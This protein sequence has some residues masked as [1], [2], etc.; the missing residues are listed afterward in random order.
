MQ[1]VAPAGPV[2]AGARGRGA[3]R[4]G[5]GHGV[6]LPLLHQQSIARY[7]VG[8]QLGQQ[9]LRHPHQEQLRYALDEEVAHPRRHLVGA[10][11]AIVDVQDYDGDDYGERHHHH[12]E[13]D[14]LAQQRQGEGGRWDDFGDEEEEH[15][16]R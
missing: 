7:F 4:A 8:G 9:V 16:L 12:G 10:G 6:Q 13:Q 14:V 1:S 15:G 11:L 2:P 3:G 5:R